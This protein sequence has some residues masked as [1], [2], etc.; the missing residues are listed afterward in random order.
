MPVKE[1]VNNQQHRV[2]QHIQRTEPDG[3]HLVHSVTEALEGIDAEESP[4]E[5]ANGNPGDRH[6]DDCQH[7]PADQVTPIRILFLTHCSVFSQ[8]P[9]NP[10]L[11]QN[12]SGS[13]W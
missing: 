3:D 10:S 11:R 9:S 5:K 13:S 6:S 12:S 4:L 1:K 8:D 7:D 2:D